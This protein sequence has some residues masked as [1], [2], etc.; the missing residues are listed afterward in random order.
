[1][2]NPWDIYSDSYQ[3]GGD[4]FVK[5]GQDALGFSQR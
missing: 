2:L 3:F 4:W 1:M 5:A